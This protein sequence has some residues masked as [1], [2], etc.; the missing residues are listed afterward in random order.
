MISPPELD[1]LPISEAPPDAVARK[2][3]PK[4]K[5]SSYPD[6]SLCRRHGLWFLFHCPRC[7]GDIG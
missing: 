3:G 6:W 7:E 1:S 2:A 4:P 5:S